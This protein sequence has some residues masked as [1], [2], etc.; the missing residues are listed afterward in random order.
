MKVQPVADEAALLFDK[1]IVLADLHIGIELDFLESGFVI[2]KQTER[3]LER[4]IAMIDR[5]KAE[6]VVIVGDLKHKIKGVSPQ[7]R[8]E[9][10]S[11]F[12]RLLEVVP[13]VH[14]VP[15]N[16]DAYILDFLPEEVVSHSPKGFRLEDMGFSHG[17]SWPS[18]EPMEGKI[19]CMGHVHPSVLFVDRLGLRMTRR[20]WLRADFK[21]G[22]KRYERHPQELILMPTF[23]DFCG[24]FPVNDSKSK[25]I[26]PLLRSELIDLENSRIYLLNG[27]DLGKLKD[28]M[29]ASES[30]S[31]V[32]S[33][34]I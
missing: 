19:L 1:T 7:E 25:P 20:C 34:L 21:E 11:F 23:N 26:G 5:C 30:E 24:G 28:L 33:E 29:I 9:V 15:G 27:V 18:A 13:D 3:M 31:A 2:P 6:R 14:L 4:L 32:D 8:R 10:P 12:E 16:H 17:S 22:G